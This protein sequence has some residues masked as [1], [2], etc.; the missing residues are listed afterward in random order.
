QVVVSPRSPKGPQVVEIPVDPTI[1]DAGDHNGSTFYQHARFLELVRAGG[2]PEVSLRDGAQAVAMGHAAQEA[3]RGGGAVTLDL[4]DVGSDTR[5]S[6][7]G[8]MG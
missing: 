8:A 7:E 1:L 3:A 5:V 2:A 4:P 6:Q